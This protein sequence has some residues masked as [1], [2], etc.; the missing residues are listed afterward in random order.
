VLSSFRNPQVSFM[1][2]GFPI[3]LHNANAD[4]VIARRIV[5]ARAVSHASANQALG[6][7]LMD[8][9]RQ[10]LALGF[11]I[12]RGVSNHIRPMGP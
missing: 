7:Q 2:T 4:L 1:V 3:T 6:L 12:T 11:V 8:Q 9:S 10:F 5:I